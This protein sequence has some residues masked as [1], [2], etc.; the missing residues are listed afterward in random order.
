MFFVIKVTSIETQKCGFIIDSTAE[1]LKISEG[2]VTSEIAQFKEFRDANKFCETHDL[3]KNPR[4]KHQILSNKEM[5]KQAGK[6]RIPGVTVAT[7]PLYYLVDNEGRKVIYETQAK[8]YIFR[9]TPDGF[10]IWHTKDEVRQFAK[11]YKIDITDEH[12]KCI[13]PKSSN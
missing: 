5:I 10:C 4:I 6:T 3:F 7:N 2:G 8:V 1:G 13:I 11:H 9:D 12:I